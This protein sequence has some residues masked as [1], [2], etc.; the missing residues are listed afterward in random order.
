MEEID[1]ND[2]NVKTTKET[3]PGNVTEKITVLDLFR[4]MKIGV[5]TVNMCFQWFSVTMC[6]FGLSF[7]STSLAGDPYTNFILRFSNIIQN[8]TKLSC[9]F[10][11]SVLAEIP[12]AL[13]ALFVMNCWGRRPI[14]V[15]SQVGAKIRQK[16]FVDSHFS[17]VVSGI[18]CIFC[19]LLQGTTD[20][21]LQGLQVD[22]HQPINCLF[23]C[24]IQILSED[25][26]LSDWKVRI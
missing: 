22:S 23:V 8:P 21:S 11:V 9:L 3:E 12:G 13:F 24:L 4:P 10:A 15:F 2:L 20:P 17:K 18:A 7:A 5:R 14:L 25:L 1:L 6:Y 16:K 26:P 19:G